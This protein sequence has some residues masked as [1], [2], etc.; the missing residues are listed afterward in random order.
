MNFKYKKGLKFSFR[1]D[2]DIW[3]FIDGKLAGGPSAELH[4]AAP[5]YIDLD[6]ITGTSGALITQKSYPLDIFLRPPY[7]YEQRPY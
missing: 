1:G 5:A 3:V 2:D 6:T 7:E 4:L